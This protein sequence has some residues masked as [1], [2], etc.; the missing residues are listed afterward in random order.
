MFQFSPPI[1]AEIVILSFQIY[2]IS[3]IGAIM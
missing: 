3:V 1:V 2:V